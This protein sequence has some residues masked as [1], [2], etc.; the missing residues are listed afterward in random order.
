MSGAPR[1]TNSWAAL[2][3]KPSGLARRSSLFA[4]PKSIPLAF[5]AMTAQLSVWD[6]YLPLGSSKRLLCFRSCKVYIWI[7]QIEQKNLKFQNLIWRTWNK[8]L[9]QL[10]LAHTLLPS[11]YPSDP[12][13]YP[14]VGNHTHG[15]KGST[16]STM[17]SALMF[18]TAKFP[19]KVVRPRN[20]NMEI[21][22]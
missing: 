17:R 4:P 12:L 10:F 21:L 20:N 7:E 3:L 13:L 18:P 22:W 6:I 5:E 9:T 19:V 8:L 14:R 2:R 1:R 15:G 11:M 16:N